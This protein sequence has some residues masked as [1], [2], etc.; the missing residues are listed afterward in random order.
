MSY[1]L[2]ALKKA[3]AEREQ[4]SVPGL[5]SQ[6]WS[7]SVQG[8]Q[9]RVRPHGRG[10]AMGLLLMVTAGVGLWLWRSTAVTEQSVAVTATEVPAVQSSPVQPLAAQAPNTSLPTPAPAPVASV[11]ATPLPP[12]QL[13]VAKAHSPAPAAPVGDRIVKW[14]DMTPVQRQALAKLT[15]GGAMHSTDPSARMVIIN[16]QVVR[17][18]DALGPGPGAG[19]H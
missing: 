8:P 15:W 16:D 13:K 3:E 10:L 11:A 9:G 17:E 19:A 7:P 1:I 12:P 14:A 4:G 18:G 6:A 2:E 5:H